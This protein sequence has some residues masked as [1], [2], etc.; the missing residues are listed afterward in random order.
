MKRQH[1]Y[2]VRMYTTKPTKSSYIQRHYNHVNA[3]FTTRKDAQKY[4]EILKKWWESTDYKP[5]VTCE[6]LIKRNEID[7]NKL[8]F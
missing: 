2:S 5:I 8:P 4:A 1:V 3:I 6:K 7:F